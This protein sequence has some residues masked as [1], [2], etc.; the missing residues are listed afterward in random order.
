MTMTLKKMEIRNIDI[1]QL[2][3][4]DNKLS[5][6]GYVNKTGQPSVLLGEGNNQFHEIM[7]PG[8]FKDAISRA[9]TIDFLLEHDNEKV[10]ASTSNGSL[11]VNEDN[12][13]LFMSADIIPTIYGHDGYSLIKSKI[14]KGMSFGMEVLDDS[15]SLGN[16]GYPLRR[17][18]KINLYE[19]SAVRYPAYSES[20]LE[21]RGIKEIRDIPVP[22]REELLDQGEKESSEVDTEML[23]D[24]LDALITAVSQL[25]EAMSP[26]EDRAGKKK[27]FTAE[28][29]EPAARA[30]KENG[31][32]ED[33]KET[34]D[35]DRDGK[36]KSAQSVGEVKMPTP[37]AKDVKKAD[38]KAEDEKEP[39]GSDTQNG[40]DRAGK[41]KAFN[42]EVKMPTPRSKSC[43]KNGEE[44]D[45]S[46]VDVPASG[47]EADIPDTDVEQDS[48]KSKKLDDKD[49][50]KLEQAKRSL[51]L[52]KKSGALEAFFN[53]KEV[54]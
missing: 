20:L 49:K 36:K 13:G 32:G 12:T 40:E 21:A 2:S 39:K 14:I 26:D 15:W 51:E 24:K 22:S 17:V 50:Q 37:R 38:E 45:D 8:V 33:Q 5:V 23:N 35:E 30:K 47:G 46:D 16:D 54:E 41:K 7:M 53:S 10:L 31:D 4:D 6:R 11:S 48:K 27:A 42:A 29:K 44:R 43:G 18:N 34:K 1:S 19:V 25:C 9:K 52:A 3:F 28:V